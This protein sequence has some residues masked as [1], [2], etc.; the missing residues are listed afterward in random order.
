MAWKQRMYTYVKFK[1][2]EQFESTL[3]AMP[4]FIGNFYEGWEDRDELVRKQSLKFMPLADIHL[5]MSLS[6]YTIE[7]RTKEIGIRKVIGASVAGIVMLVSSKF[8][9]L[10][11]LGFILAIPF[12]K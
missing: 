3:A 2:P 1:S 7:S 11:M 4:G 6:A 8:F 12:F 10:V 5:L 9:K